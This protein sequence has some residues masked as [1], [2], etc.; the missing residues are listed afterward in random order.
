MYLV[1]CELYCGE[2]EYS[3]V[4]MY[5]VRVV[6]EILANICQS[7]RIHLKLFENFL[8]CPSYPPVTFVTITF[9]SSGQLPSVIIF[10][11]CFKED[12]STCEHSILFLLCGR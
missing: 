10:V 12:V 4:I 5:D 3:Q 9:P 7:T 6:R 1:S 11:D 8:F 2:V